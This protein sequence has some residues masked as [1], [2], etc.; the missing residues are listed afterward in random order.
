MVI[1]E[2]P[3]PPTSHTGDG[4]PG[5]EPEILNKAMFVF[6]GEFLLGSQCD[7]S[8]CPNTSVSPKTIIS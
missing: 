5:R 7:T 8:G 6:F 1:L 3:P 2:H 4:D